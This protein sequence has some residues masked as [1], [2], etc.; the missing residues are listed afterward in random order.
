VWRESEGVGIVRN[1]DT[2]EG[3]REYKVALFWKTILGRGLCSRGMVP[4]FIPFK[5]EELQ[6]NHMGL[7]TI[8]AFL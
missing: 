2:I 8:P 7:G 3:Q 5:S 1:G 6:V 4:S